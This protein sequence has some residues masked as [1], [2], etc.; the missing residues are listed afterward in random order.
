MDENWIVTDDATDLQVDNINYVQDGSSLKFNLIASGSKGTLENTAL[1]P[2]NMTAYVNQGTFFLW[3]YLPTAADFTS[4]S[5]SWGSSIT[6][7]YTAS[8]TMTQQNTVFQDGWNLLSFAWLGCSQNGTPDYT[9]ITSV[10]ISYYY[11]GNAQT[12]TR[13]GGLNLQLGQIYDLEYYS[14]YMFRDAS[15]GAFQQHITDDSNLINLGQEAQQLLLYKTVIFAAQQIQGFN[16]T[17]SD[18]PYFEQEYA[19]ALQL[20]KGMYKSEVFKPRS[21]YYSLPSGG[22]TEYFNARNFY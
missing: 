13:F 17:L 1:P 2:L 15:T 19:N 8:A 20:Y 10:W 14:S 7:Y 6:D 5:L 3:V 11:N 9:A 12:A 4:G 18:L 21:N 22:Y 16:A